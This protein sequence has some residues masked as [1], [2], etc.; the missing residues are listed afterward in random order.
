[1]DTI[2]ALVDSLDAQRAHVL[3]IV[4]GLTDAAL[5]RAPLPTGWNCVGMLH[6]L[7]VDVEEFWFRPDRGR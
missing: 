6:H 3:G 1:M 7:A 4:D 2:A 5:R